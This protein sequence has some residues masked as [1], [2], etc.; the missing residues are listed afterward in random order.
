M[1]RIYLS[2][3]HLGE[4]ELEL[5]RE[6]F[7]SNWIAPLGPQVDAFESEFASVLRVSGRDG[8]TL[9]PVMRNA[10]DS[11]NLRILTKNN[12]VQASEAHISIIGHI[13][14]DELL[15]YMDNT[16]AANGFANRF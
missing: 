1:S 2:P 4:R 3:P 5:T 8:N 11:G 6:A 13:T 15:R 12:P 16:E 7:E 9:S 10:W 14:R